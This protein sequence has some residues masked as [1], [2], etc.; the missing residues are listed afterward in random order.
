MKL[1]PVTLILFMAI[2]PVS[3][4]FSQCAKCVTLFDQIKGDKLFISFLAIN[5]SIV[6]LY[7]DNAK[8]SPRPN[9]L[10]EQ[11]AL[12][13]RD[14]SITVDQ[15]FDSMGYKGLTVIR[16]LNAQCIATLSKLETAY[17]LLKTLTEKEYLD[18]IKM[19]T[20]YYYSLKKQ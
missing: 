18:F 20:E 2:L 15:K 8:N 19:S 5:D 11:D 9:N 7:S 3:N 17:P 1:V 4:C 10:R 12:Y 6:N 14:R 13:M 16:A